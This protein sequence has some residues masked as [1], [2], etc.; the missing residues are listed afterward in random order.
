MLR[1]LA[2]SAV[3][4]AALLLAAASCID[5][6]PVAD[7]RAS[8]SCEEGRT[9]EPFSV[10]DSAGVRIVYSYH[11]ARS[12]PVTLERR[13]SVDPG[14]AADAAAPQVVTGAVR[15]SDGRI[16]VATRGGLRVFDASGRPVAGTGAVTQFRDISAL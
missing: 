3:G 1:I 7:L 4:S 16:L 5:E 2:C 13:L 11:P 12:A 6:P 14:A 10:T 15:L 9:R 8:D